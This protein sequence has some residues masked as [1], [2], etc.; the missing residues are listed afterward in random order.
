MVMS[1]VNG[2]SKL[3][4]SVSKENHDS[5]WNYYANLQS[6]Y[7]PRFK[8]GSPEWNLNATLQYECITTY[9]THEAAIINN[10]HN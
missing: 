5:T 4:Q 3:L 6:M 7:R 1:V 10:P 8:S 2:N 9:I